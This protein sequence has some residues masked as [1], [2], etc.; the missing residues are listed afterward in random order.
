MKYINSLN[1]ED[2]MM[3]NSK[4][5]AAL[6][7]SL[8]MTGSLAA[9]GGNANTPGSADDNQSAGIMYAVEAGSAGEAI[10][11]ENGYTYNAVS[12]QADALMEVASGTSEAAIIDL[13]MATKL[14]PSR[15]EARRLI[16]QGGISVDDEKLTALDAAV[17]QTA[18]EKGYVVIRKGKKT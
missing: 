14:A 3:K 16:E 11:K 2:D 17:P 7:L 5:L 18:F 15:G 1:L 13:L 10:A 6:A 12:S 4:K 9:C 8:A